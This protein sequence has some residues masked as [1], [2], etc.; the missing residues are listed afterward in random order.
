MRTPDGKTIRVSSAKTTKKG[1]FAIPSLQLK[2]PGTYRLQIKFGK[3]TRTVKVTVK[4]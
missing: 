2:K 1:S 3:V 4:R